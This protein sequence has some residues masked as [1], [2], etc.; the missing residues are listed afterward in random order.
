MAFKRPQFPAVP[1]RCFRRK[2]C[3]TLDDLKS[4]QLTCS[5]H[6]RWVSVEPAGF[7]APACPLDGSDASGCNE[8]TQM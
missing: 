2:A 3:L 6:G 4:T 5:E 1:H 8:I 7:N